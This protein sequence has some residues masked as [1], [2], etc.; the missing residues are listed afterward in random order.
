MQVRFTKMHGAG[1]DFVVI[2]ATAAPFRPTP[3]LL[4]RLADRRFGVGCDQILVVEPPA[5]PDVDFNY[6]I[7]NADGSESGQCGNGARA[8]ARYVRE[9]GLS[10]KRA[11]RV[12]T[13]TATMMLEQ[14]GDGLYRVDMG[15]P[16]FDPAA[17]PFDAAERSDRY[18][19]T[20]DGGAVVEI[21][22]VNMG[23]PHAV[24]RVGDVDTAPVEQVGRLLQAHAS[25]P[26]SVNAGF[27]Q[28]VDRGRARLRVFERGVGETL[29][30]GSGAC[31]AAVVGRIW[32]LLDAR[33]DMQMAGGVLTIEWDGQGG[34]VLMTGPAETVFTGEIEWPN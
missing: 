33:V 3:S 20:L 19:L 11:I 4:Q 2:D 21:G 23:N 26:Q 16:Q 1:N 25:F 32:G 13:A 5:S 27:L 7:Y 29:A 24:M 28:I 14:A 15:V 8:L 18:A 12:R 34:P 30:C 9:S 10:D 31:A 17:I 6:R 22:A